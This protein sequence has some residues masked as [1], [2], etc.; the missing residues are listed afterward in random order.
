MTPRRPTHVVDP[1][2]VGERIRAAR[3]ERGLSLRQAAFPGCSPSYLSRLENGK[4]I[5][6]LPLLEVIAERLGVP[7]QSLSGDVTGLEAQLLSVELAV[8]LGDPDVVDM[9][10]EVRERARAEGNRPAEARLVEALGHRAIAARDDEAAIMLFEE[11]LALRRAAPRERPDLYRALGRAYAGVGDLARAIETLRAGF[12]AAREEPRDVA[13]LVRFGTYL[14]NAYTDNG[15]FGEALAVL[16][17]VLRHEDAVTEPGNRVRLDWAL[18]RTYAEQGKAAAAERHAR[19]VVAAQDKTDDPAAVG[20]SRLLLAGILLDL[21]ELD[22]ALEHLDQADKLLG[23]EPG[24]ERA[25]LLVEQA[26]ASLLLGR[27]EDARAA[28]RS[29][30]DETEATEPSIAGG[31]YLALAEA[32]LRDGDP[33]EARLLLDEALSA[34]AGRVAPIH[35][36]RAFELLSE[37][38][39]REGDLPRAIAALR[40][41]RRLADPA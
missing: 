13:L 16:A 31:A 34:L 30:L 11:S 21:G 6:S 19:R 37:L 35:R 8:R 32:E 25:L 20:H 14:A 1:V 39:E 18:A 23:A 22:A 24:P 17:E 41:G 3:I 9:I 40:A 36:A 27:P 26:R 10:D 33:G 5:P 29:A 12:D 4:R 7:A 2:A 28:A 15:A 38:E